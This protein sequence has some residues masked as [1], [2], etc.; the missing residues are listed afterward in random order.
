MCNIGGAWLARAAPGDV[1]VFDGLQ[2]RVR[3]NR[4]DKVL[5]FVWKHDNMSFDVPAIINS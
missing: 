4:C 5:N 2:K 1:N 3:E